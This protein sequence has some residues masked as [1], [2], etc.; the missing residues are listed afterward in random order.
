MHI[1]TPTRPS[2][3]RPLLYFTAV[4][5]VSCAL[6]IL[7]IDQPLTRFI[8]QHTA[9]AKPFFAAYTT[10]LDDAYNAAVDTHLAGLPVLYVA[11]ILAYVLGRR[12]LR[13]QGRKRRGATLFLIIL[14]THIASRGSSNVLKGV[15]HRFRPEVLLSTGYKGTGLLATGPHND[16]FPS[17]HTAIY[18]SLFWPL[19]VAFPRYRVPLLVL[20]GLIMVGRLVLGMHYVSDVWFS[21]WQA[22][23]WTAL[24]TLLLSWRSKRA[25]QREL[26]G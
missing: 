11:L 26:A 16:S 23:M 15:V 14:F 1:Q 18:L 17:T 8:H 7:F 25:R 24:F 5:L 3:L 4:T 21:A 9:W 19:A 2:V 13:Y 6:L 22:V 10:A 20:P 12:V